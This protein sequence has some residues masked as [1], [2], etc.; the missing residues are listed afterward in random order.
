MKYN[1]QKLYIVCCIMYIDIL[2]SYIFYIFKQY[3]IILVNMINIFLLRLQL[4]S[5]YY[6]FE[7]YDLI[8]HN[9]QY[10]LIILYIKI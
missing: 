10:F 2:D 4:K 9:R 7:Y 6:K 8:R 1:E 3:N 5:T